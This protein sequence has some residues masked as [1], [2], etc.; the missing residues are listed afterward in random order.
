MKRIY[1]LRHAKSS[2]KNEDLPDHDRPLAGRGRSA[3]KAIARHMRAKAIEP[4][5][6]LCSTALRVRQ[7]LER[8]E[9]ALGRRSV[10]VEAELYGAGAHA[11]LERLRAIPDT[12]SSVMIIGHNPGVQQLVLDLARPGPHVAAVR[13]KFPTAA[14]ATLAFDGARWAELDAGGAELVAFVRPRDLRH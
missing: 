5:L 12:V 1:L 9:P 3:A 11:L 2:W 10:R 14:L 8:I 7:T 6:V 4:E 13:V